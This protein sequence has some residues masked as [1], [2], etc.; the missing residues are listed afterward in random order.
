MAASLI[1]AN[2]LGAPYATACI[3]TYAG[4]VQ[5]LMYAG[6]QQEI[7]RTATRLEEQYKRE[8]S[9]EVANDWAVA[10]IL[11]GN[12]P[13]AIRV[14]TQLE[15]DKPGLSKTAS[16]LGTALELSGRNTEALHWIQEG[17][18]RNPQDHEGTEWLHVKIL[19]T[20]IA[21]EKDANWLQ[22]H[23]VLGIDFGTEELPQAPAQDV[24][25]HLGA[26]RSLQQTY[27]AIDYQL[28]ERLKFVSAPDPLVADL[29]VTQANIS[30]L[31]HVGIPE[32]YI[33]AA[34]LF[35][36]HD[37]PRLTPRANAL[38]KNS[39]RFG[40]WLVPLGIGA[41]GLALFLYRRARRRSRALQ[42]AS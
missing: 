19:E 29:Y 39:S 24:R 36:A 5:Q 30:H 14:L 41:L 1:G 12:Y 33:D 27:K 4:Q 26:P 15:H 11:A 17:I 28:R 13:K 8:H 31:L 23:S 21:L 7:A 22:T 6:D 10:L 40:I 37:L 32:D 18:Q 38:Q 3:N 34:V 2:L 25:D 20:K 9:P 16:N 42:S 35:G